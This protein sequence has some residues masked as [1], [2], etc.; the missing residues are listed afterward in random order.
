MGY[1][2]SMGQAW[3]FLCLASIA[4]SLLHTSN[5]RAS[6]VGIASRLDESGG[7][8]SHCQM[9]KRST[10]NPAAIACGPSPYVHATEQ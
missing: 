4:F 9:A 7:A 8:S 2:L 5:T 1:G 3:P 10:L 6:T